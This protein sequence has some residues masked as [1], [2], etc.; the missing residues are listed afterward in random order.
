MVRAQRR[1]PTSLFLLF[2]LFSDAL[3]VP[4]SAYFDFPRLRE[5][6]VAVDRYRTLFVARHSTLEVHPDISE[7]THFRSSIPHPKTDFN[8]LRLLPDN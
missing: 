3:V 5:W 1:S 2:S 6:E 8:K 4:R 7:D